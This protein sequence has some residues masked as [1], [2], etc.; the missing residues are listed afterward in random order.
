MLF[1]A[2]RQKDVDESFLYKENVITAHTE[3]LLEETQ[4][5]TS[6]C[7]KILHWVDLPYYIIN[8]IRLS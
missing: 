4:G 8:S 6:S 2:T 1:Q 3:A 7:R 5:N